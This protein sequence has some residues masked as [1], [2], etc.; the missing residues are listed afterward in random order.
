MKLAR[1][2]LISIVLFFILSYAL[3]WLLSPWLV[4]TFAADTLAEHNVVLDSNS[5]VRVNLFNS[6]LKIKTLSLLQDD[7]VEYEL[8]QLQLYYSFWA[9]FKKEVHIKRV[10]LSGMKLNVL[11][12]GDNIVVAGVD[13]NSFTD[14]EVLEESDDENAEPGFVDTL[15]YLAPEILLENINI[16]LINEGHAHTILINTLA[17]KQSEYRNQV[18][19]SSIELDAVFDGALIEM[20]T[21]VTVETQTAKADLVV[22][23]KEFDTAF[24]N[25][26]LP[27]EINKLDA[28]V[29]A[30]LKLNLT[31]DG[32]LLNINSGSLQLGVNDL[33][34]QEVL[35][36]AS[37]KSF[38]LTVPQLTAQFNIETSDVM[39]NAQ[40]QMAL[41]TLNVGLTDSPIILSTLGRLSTSD[42]S[43]EL[44]GEDYKITGDQIQL[45]GLMAS[46]VSDE[47]PAL[48]K[49]DSLNI[50]SFDVT[51]SVVKMDHIELGGGD[52][53][54][55]LDKEYFLET[56]L[57]TDILTDEVVVPATQS[58][59]AV[60]SDNVAVVQTEQEVELLD[61]RIQIR[62]ITLID[63]MNVV[64]EDKSTSEIFKKV[65]IVTDAVIDGVDSSELTKQT[66]FDIKFAD[67]SYFKGEAKGWITPF[68]YQ[69]NFYADLTMREFPLHEVAPYLKDS[70]GFEVKAGQMDLDFSGSVR[71][72]ILQSDSVVLLRGAKF[73]N[74]KQDEGSN[75]IGK[76][77]IPLN[78]AL[79]M[80]RDRD[81]NIELKIPVHGDV[82]D[83]S[84]GVGSIVG[85][86][87][88]KVAMAQAKSYLLNLFVPYAKVVSVALSAGD[89]A[90][91]VRFEDLQYAPS[92]TEI[93][94]AQSEFVGQITA[95]LSDKEDVVVRVCPIATKDD[96]L[97][98]IELE[99]A[100]A[101]KEAEVI[102]VEPV[103]VIESAEII[104]EPEV[105]ESVSV[106][107][108]VISELQYEQ[109]LALATK[110]AETFKLKLVVEGKIDSSRLLI[111]SP[112]VDEKKKAIPRLE[113]GA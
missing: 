92:Q 73:G 44:K 112:K 43:V 72:D 22:K 52:T 47:L 38:E 55:S 41:S 96:L 74:T 101:L 66:Q 69:L 90:L 26:L 37:L 49:M 103:E 30:D 35:Y 28:K 25:Y 106:E 67:E 20:N 57:D 63:P 8:D 1:N 102:E 14:S 64:I 75:I 68:T 88:K 86:V 31:L 12:Q 97:A 113:F 10:Y 104:Q 16:D 84:F 46:K 62:Q 56:L 5:T 61:P 51:P 40:V 71:N 80:L 110:R 87:V 107:D 109:L 13:I 36:E 54:V 15:S 2:S 48:L 95:L 23:L 70:L 7:E 93:G 60:E 19:V 42:L 17:L 29:N 77:V 83:P 98:L 21:D 111:C 78:V 79:G 11:M 4:R 34:M 99:K 3:V 85:L 65:F 91:K 81:G 50:N 24:Y 6:S 27:D 9:L 18:L 100:A 94:E 82:Y 76:A 89:L 59:D 33:D 105:V 108:F 58:T 45:E 53:Y 39:A 32:D